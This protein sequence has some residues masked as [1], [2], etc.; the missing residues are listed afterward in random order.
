[1]TASILHINFHPSNIRLRVHTYLFP[2]VLR[3]DRLITKESGSSIA[4]AGKQ[5]VVVYFNAF[6]VR[7]R[8]SSSQLRVSTAMPKPPIGP[9]RLSQILKS[10]KAEPR[11][12]LTPSLKSLKLTYAVRNDHFGARCVP[13]LPNDPV[14]STPY[15]HS[16]VVR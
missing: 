13:S 11:P 16:D 10:L 5:M 9:S 6:R 7:S 14:T 2:A 12:V 4:A 3:L 15:A 8:S 1:M